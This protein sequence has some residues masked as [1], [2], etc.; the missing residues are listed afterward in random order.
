[1]A[2]YTGFTTV[3]ALFYFWQPELNFE[4]ILKSIFISFMAG[5]IS[6]VSVIFAIEKSNSLR[7]K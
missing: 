3:L 1:V 2:S 6:A 5:G 7:Q 4:S